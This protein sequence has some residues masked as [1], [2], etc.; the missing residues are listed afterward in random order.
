MSVIDNI[1]YCYVR[2]EGEREW[3]SAHQHQRDALISFLNTPY[4]NFEGEIDVSINYQVQDEEVEFNVS[5]GRIR[6]DMFYY[7]ENG[8][9]FEVIVITDNSYI[10]FLN[11]LG[12]FM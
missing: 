12:Q 4:M 9:R 2:Q 3:I 8:Q 6:N 7:L 10:S 1:N 5:F 11:R